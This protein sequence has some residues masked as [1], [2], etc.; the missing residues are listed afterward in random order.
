MGLYMC[1][2]VWVSVWLGASVYVYVYE[3]VYM[4]LW[5]SMVADHPDKSV[6]P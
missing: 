2:R 5:F 6:W 1:A 4:C 3:S